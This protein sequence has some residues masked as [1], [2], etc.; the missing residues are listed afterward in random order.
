MR[1][2]ISLILQLIFPEQRN[3]SGIG[4]DVFRRTVELFSFIE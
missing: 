3:E 1:K 4:T 2:L